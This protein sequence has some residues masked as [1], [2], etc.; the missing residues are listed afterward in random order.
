MS[1]DQTRRALH[2][3]AELLISGPQYQRHGTIR[4]TITRG[5][6]GGTEFPVRVDG[7][8]LVWAK[9][10]ARIV[11]TLRDVAD[12]AEVDAGAPHGIYPNGSGVTLDEVIEIDPAAARLICG[13][14]ALGDRALR[15]FAPDQTPVLWP[16]HFD[17][18]ITLENTTYG[19]SPGDQHVDSPYAY[20]APA[21]WGDLGGTDPFWNAGFG[22]FRTIDDIPTERSMIE[23]FEAGRKM[24]LNQ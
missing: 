17:L 19:V 18:S 23:F 12:R 20:V 21:D 3:V 24:L 11:G 10:R 16:E 5:G 1:I 6:F 2:G 22:A 9:G 15:H 7:I 8:E 4:L 13:W 14:F